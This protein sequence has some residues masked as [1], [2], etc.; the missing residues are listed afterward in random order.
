[1][2]YTLIKHVFFNQSEHV[3][4]SVYILN[5]VLLIKFEDSRSQ[6]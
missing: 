6:L 5:K 2:Y 4:F 3:Q 1:M